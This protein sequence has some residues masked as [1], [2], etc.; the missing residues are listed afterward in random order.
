MEWDSKQIVTKFIHW[1]LLKRARVADRNN[2][3][4][5]FDMTED[6]VQGIRQEKEL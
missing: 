4:V 2:L 6:R 3:S 1:Y 5:V